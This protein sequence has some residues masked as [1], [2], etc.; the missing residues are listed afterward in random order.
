M[1]RAEGKYHP[2][3]HSGVII[4]CKIIDEQKCEIGAKDVSE[5]K[6]DVVNE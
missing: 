6:N 5:K 4:F 3:D 1:E 2:T